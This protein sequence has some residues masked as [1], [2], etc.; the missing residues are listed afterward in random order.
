VVL[1]KVGIFQADEMELRAGGKNRLGSFLLARLG[2]VS[3]G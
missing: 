2:A 3:L 1:R